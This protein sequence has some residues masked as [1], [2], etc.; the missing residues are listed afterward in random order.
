MIDFDAYLKDY[1]SLGISGPVT[2]HF[3]YEL[4]GAESGSRNITMSLDKIKNF[5]KNDL[6]MLKMK[7]NDHGLLS[8]YN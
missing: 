7:F 5:M 3:E 8:S 2:I 4:G 6:A 1:I